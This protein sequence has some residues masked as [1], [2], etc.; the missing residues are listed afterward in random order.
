[1]QRGFLGHHDD[2]VRVANRL[3]IA[4]WGDHF[5]GCVIQKD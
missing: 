1:M 4:H 2:G 3:G 5:F